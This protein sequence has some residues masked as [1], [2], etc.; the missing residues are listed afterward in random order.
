MEKLKKIFNINFIK[1]K[2]Y[3]EDAII[4]YTKDKVYICEKGSESYVTNNCV[5]YT[6]KNLG[7]NHNEQK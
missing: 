3:T 4:I 7:G 6:L 2:K 5:E 1:K